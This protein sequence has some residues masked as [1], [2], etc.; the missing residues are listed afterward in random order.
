MKNLTLLLL[1]LAVVSPLQA[2]AHE[3]R[4]NQNIQIDMIADDGSVYPVYDVTQK[5]GAVE[6]VNRAYLEAINGQNYKIR[7]RNLKQRRI[8]LVVTVDGRNIISGQKSHLNSTERM[9]ILEPYGQAVFDGWRTDQNQV[10]RFFFTAAENSYAEA[11]GDKSAMGV[12]A[13][14]VFNE[15]PK[16]MVRKGLRSRLNNTV[17]D[18]DKSS[19][20]EAEDSLAKSESRSAPQAGTGF[21]EQTYSPVRL[22]QF[23]ANR[24]PVE[25]Y[26]YKYEWRDALCMKQ[27]VTLNCRQPENRFWPDDHYSKNEAGHGY[28]PYPKWL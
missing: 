27:I 15:K 23:Q 4:S 26:F 21:G 3:S 14:A 18:A 1:F 17:G 5:H 19:A 28:A 25:K 10:H 8:G 16:K 7:V 20:S 11:F 22:V 13:L 9:Y 2:C 6:N 12:I 24:S